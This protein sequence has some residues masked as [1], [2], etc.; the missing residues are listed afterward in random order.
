MNEIMIVRNFEYIEQYHI[1]RLDTL[2]SKGLIAKTKTN[3]S[4][5]P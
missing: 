5:K 1:T 4:A 2:H 3:F